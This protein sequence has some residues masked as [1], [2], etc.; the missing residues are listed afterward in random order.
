MG[1]FQP[2]HQ[3]ALVTARFWGLDQA[4]DLDFDSKEKDM[5]KVLLGSLLRAP[6]DPGFEAHRDLL[7]AGGETGLGI[8]GAK[9][10]QNWTH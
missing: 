7:M 5:N 1:G 3:P 10:E 4:S 8:R 9:A 2:P 6:Y